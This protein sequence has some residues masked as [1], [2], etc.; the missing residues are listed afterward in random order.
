MSAKETP[1]ARAARLIEGLSSKTYSAGEVK[2]MLNTITQMGVMPTAKSVTMAPV[3]EIHRGDVFVAPGVGGKS[4]PWVVTHVYDSFVVAIAMSSGENAPGA[5]PLN[6]RFWPGS[7]LGGATAQFSRD[8][9]G[10]SVTRPLTDMD[11]LDRAEE[12]VVQALSGQYVSSVVSPTVFR[13][14]RA[15]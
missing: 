7:W 13:S 9:A 15:A 4:R 1:Q 14:R 11:T 12:M 2:T 5:L 6:C 3:E 10:V 8:V